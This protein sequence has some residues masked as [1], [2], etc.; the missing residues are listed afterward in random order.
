MA[1]KTTFAKLDVSIAARA[2]FAG[3]TVLVDYWTL[4]KP[5][6]DF[7][8]VITTFASFYLARVAPLS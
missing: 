2:R 4:T 5:E 3:F 1:A 8:I 7:L 6:V